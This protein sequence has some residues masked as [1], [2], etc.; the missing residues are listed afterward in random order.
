MLSE[1]DYLLTYIFPDVD[2]R[3]REHGMRLTPVDLRGIRLDGSEE[4]YD[5]ECFRYCMSEI[6]RS[7]SMI[8]LVGSRYG[9]VI[10]CGP[11]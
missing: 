11:C 2:G 8:G 7:D 5:K 1:R 3:L 9:W 4:W 10:W 6:D